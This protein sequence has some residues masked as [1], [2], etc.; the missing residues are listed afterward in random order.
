[1]TLSTLERSVETR[2]PLDLV[3]EMV[4][5][6]EWIFER[7]GVDELFAETAGQWCTYR[8][9]FLWQEDLAALQFTVQFDMRVPDKRR[10]AVCE[11]LA[12]LNEKLWLGHLEVDGDEKTPMFRHTMLMRGAPGMSVEQAEDLLDIALTECDRFYPAFQFCIWGGRSAADSLN[13]AILDTVA[14][15]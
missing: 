5:V 7:T 13:S 2:N 8:M 4:S 12:A 3:E 1:M 9:F 14:E 15:A 11:L 6:N 10:A